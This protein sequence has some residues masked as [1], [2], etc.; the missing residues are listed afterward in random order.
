MTA[1]IGGPLRRSAMHDS[2]EPT[3]RE[4]E[5]APEHVP[6]EDAMSGH[7]HEDPESA[8]DPQDDSEVHDA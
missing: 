8:A 5:E 7:G 2:P 6:E 4:H 1:R 3:E